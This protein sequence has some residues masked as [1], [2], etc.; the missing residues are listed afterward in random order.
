MNNII[1]ISGSVS[2][3]AGRPGL[4]ANKRA[5]SDRVRS[6]RASTN[7]LDRH[8]TIVNPHGIRTEKFDANPIFVWAHDGYST[9][10][11]GPSIDSVLGKVI[12]HRKTANSFDV[13]VEFAT[14]EQ[15]PK[16]ATALKLIDGGYLS[17]VSIGFIPIRQREEKIAGRM[18]PILDE[19]ELLEVSLVP[20]PSNPEA[21]AIVRSMLGGARGARRQPHAVVTAPIAAAVRSAF[22]S[23]AQMSPRE[24][25]LQEK[26]KK[27]ERRT[28]QLEAQKFA[29]PIAERLAKRIE[30]VVLRSP[31]A[32]SQRLRGVR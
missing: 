5:R 26:I 20:I 13:D 32:L 29:A 1:R 14:A 10:F 11:G 8:G 15:N 2:S 24:L 7:A 12:S 9:L 6:F 17:A 22:R 31:T 25:I 27:I 19:V 23:V 18:V 21:L 4:R 3:A 28:R 16:A 30:Q